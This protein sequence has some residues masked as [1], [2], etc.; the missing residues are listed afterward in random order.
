MKQLQ[1]DI[2]LIKQDMRDIKAQGISTHHRLAALDSDNNRQDE[3]NIY[4]QDRLDKIEKRI[5][6]NS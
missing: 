2:G 4:I 6:I 5:E 3:S 1:H